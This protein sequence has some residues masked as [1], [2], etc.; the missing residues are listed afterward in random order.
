MANTFYMM[1]GQFEKTD[2]DVLLLSE[3][4]F[5]AD[6]ATAP[7]VD[8]KGDYKKTA[9][10]V[11]IAYATSEGNEPYYFAK[12]A[13]TG[14]IGWVDKAGQAADPTVDAGIGF[15]YR[16][17]T[18]EKPAF[19]FS[20]QVIPDSPW[21]KM[22]ATSTYYMLVNPFQFPYAIDDTTALIISNLDDIVPEVDRKGE[23]KKT[24]TQIQVPYDGD[25]GFEDYYYAKI[26]KTGR[27]GWVDKA[28]QA[29]ENITVPAGRGCWFRP[30]KADMKVSFFFNK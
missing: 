25:E 16:D 11:Q 14:R 8:R 28:G 29:V 26:A 22:F 1:G 24:A 19:T 3:I 12:I 15:W 23:Y 18:T 30:A 4:V 20:G 2:G 10:Q 21:E 7:E 17:P 27:I 9:L 6:P 13:K 5:N